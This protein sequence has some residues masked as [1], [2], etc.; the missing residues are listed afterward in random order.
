MNGM[1]STM[2]DMVEFM[3]NTYNPNKQTL[4]YSNSSEANKS[5]QQPNKF[6]DVFHHNILVNKKVD[7]L[8]EN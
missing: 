2:L 3:T 5:Q 6:R 1:G 4:F 7:Y 8:M